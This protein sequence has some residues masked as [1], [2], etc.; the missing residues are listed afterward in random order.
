MTGTGT[1]LN[2]ICN[3]FIASRSVFQ[4]LHKCILLQVLPAY[5][6]DHRDKIGRYVK[7]IMAER[8][9]SFSFRINHHHRPMIPSFRAAFSLYA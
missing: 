9:I 6:D 2:R 3:S 5:S 1:K 4:F 7:Y 8:C